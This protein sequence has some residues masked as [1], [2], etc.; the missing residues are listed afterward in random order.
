MKRFSE[1]SIS[2]LVININK[3]VRDLREHLCYR[4]GG[5][6]KSDNGD[7]NSNKMF[8]VD[9]SVPPIE[10]HFE[11]HHVEVLNFEHNN[12]DTLEWCSKE[13]IFRDEA[14]SLNLKKKADSVTQGLLSDASPEVLKHLQ[15]M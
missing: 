11:F 10:C 13:A 5:F 4:S 7:S 15:F 9:L 8:W 3:R 14:E 2:F 6:F 1:K 12:V